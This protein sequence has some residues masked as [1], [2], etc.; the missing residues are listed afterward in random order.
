MYIEYS[1]LHQFCNGMNTSQLGKVFNSEITCEVMQLEIIQLDVHGSMH[2]NN[3]K[4]G[5]WPAS[6]EDLITKY[7]KEFFV[8]IE[9]IDSDNLKV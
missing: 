1:I 3:S 2:H 9:S 7:K 8:F 5:T 4:W 6:K